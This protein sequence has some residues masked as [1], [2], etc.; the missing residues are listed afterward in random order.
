VR[1]GRVIAHVWPDG[2]QPA[3]SP[4]DWHAWTEVRPDGSFELH[5]LPE[6]QLELVAVCDGFVSTNGPGQFPTMHYPQK[7][8]L[9]TGDLDVVLGME[10]TASLEVMV[11]DDHGKPLKGA[12]VLCS[13]NVRYGEWSATVIGYDCYNTADFIRDPDAERRMVKAW[14]N[15]PPLFSA[16]SDFSGLAVVRNLPAETAQFNVQHPRFALPAM[17]TGF[18][19]KRRELRI[20]LHPPATNRITVR[21]EP[22]GQAP[23]AHY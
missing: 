16:T 8:S 13:P 23:I 20:T 5:G 3:N 19:Q 12:E 21:L 6:G 2:Q 10:P 9:S 1:N 7:F 14:W 18:G 17:D 11:Q 4:P 15:H 22:I